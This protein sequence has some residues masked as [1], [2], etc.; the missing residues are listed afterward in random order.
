MEI[1]KPDKCVSA[2]KFVTPEEEADQ[3]QAEISSIAAATTGCRSGVNMTDAP[4]VSAVPGKLSANITAMYTNHSDSSSATS[5]D[6]NMNT[7]TP[8]RRRSVLDSCN[9]QLLQSISKSIMKTQTGKPD[10]S[11]TPCALPTTSDR[12]AQNICSKTLFPDSNNT[13]AAVEPKAVQSKLLKVI[14][15]CVIIYTKYI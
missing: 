4:G 3:R 11:D 9:P 14:C 10:S 7:V 8:V 5:S 6:S 15:K 12:T 13:T 1:E 2:F